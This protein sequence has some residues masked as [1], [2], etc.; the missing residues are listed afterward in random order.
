MPSP[1]AATLYR[2]KH[3][4]A[5]EGYD[6]GIGTDGDADRL[7]IIDEKGHFI[8]PNEVLTASLLLLAWNTKAGKALSCVI[9]QLRTC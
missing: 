4:V 2:L 1:N 3:L 8:H 5:A 9:S 6:I 7:G